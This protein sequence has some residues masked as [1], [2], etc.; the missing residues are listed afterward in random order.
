MSDT[1]SIKITRDEDIGY[2]EKKNKEDYP[3]NKK[4]K[5][6]NNNNKNK[7]DKH[8]QCD[9]KK[10]ELANV[11]NKTS[12]S[13]VENKKNEKILIY[14]NNDI[15]EYDYN[16]F[17]DEQKN[18]KHVVLQEE[19]YLS[20]LEHLI[21]KKFFP[22][23]ENLRLKEDMYK[24]PYGNNYN[25]EYVDS[26][27]ESSSGYNKKE[28]IKSNNSNNKNNMEL[29][30]YFEEDEN[31]SLVN[32]VHS[33]QEYIK[34]KKKKKYKKVILPNGKEHKINL[35]ISLSEFQKRYTS[36]DNKSFEYLLRNMKNKSIEK[37]FFSIDK[38]KKHNL[39]MDMI[40]EYT[41]KGIPHNII[42]TN[43]ADEQ[44]YAMMFS[45]SYKI[46]N[47][48]SMKNDN[49]T[50][51]YH[52]T[53]FN[54]EYNNDI[55]RQINRIDD[56]REQK[57]LNKEKD[58][59]Q[60]QMIEQ[61]KFNLLKNNDNYEYVNTPLIQAGKGVDQSPIITWGKIICTPKL[62]HG[63]KDDDDKSIHNNN[64]YNYNYNYNNELDNSHDPESIQKEFNLQKINNRELVAE[65]LQNSRKN[66]KYN[67]DIL[68]KKNINFLINKNFTSH[69]SSSSFKNSVLSRYSQKRLS[70][71][72]RKS[73]LASQILTKK[74]K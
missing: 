15:V 54:N 64:D 65:K 57:I 34:E 42:N 32:Y 3:L 23:M 49:P 69:I 10:Y 12:L 33:D 7:R 40:E 70:E 26:Q 9:D 59:K 29:L 5:G 66:I 28:N 52:N 16:Y 61:G 38:R 22:E 30:K 47:V 2:A 19:D 13:V 24:N 39:K 73:S 36:E 4:K 48:E 27:S 6:N 45:S 31:Y 74:K 35:N 72:A 53:R 11:N 60:Q 55:K 20:T 21:E 56:I 37:N 44:D 67:K 8:N 17:F 43:K 63:Q 14:E 58:R 51:Y 1:S 18:N 25:D 46:S 68:K 50:I 41:K 62:V 71:L